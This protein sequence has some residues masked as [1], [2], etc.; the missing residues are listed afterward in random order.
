MSVT[1]EAKSAIE[2]AESAGKKAAAEA[3]TAWQEDFNE[4]SA[5]R[6]LISA[7]IMSV[8][9]RKTLQKNVEQDAFLVAYSSSIQDSISN[10]NTSLEDIVDTT[11]RSQWTTNDDALSILTYP[12]LADLVRNRIIKDAKIKP[13]NERAVLFACNTE[14]LK[15]DLLIQE[16]AKNPQGYLAENTAFQ[17]ALIKFIIDEKDKPITQSEADFLAA[18]E[19]FSDTASI[20][21]LKSNAVNLANN[22]IVKSKI[23]DGMV[24]AIGALSEDQKYWLVK[25][26]RHWF[27]EGFYEEAVAAAAANPNSALAFD[28][29]FHDLVIAQI[30]R[31]PRALTSPESKFLEN[32]S[33]LAAAAAK[34][35]LDKNEDPAK[36][37]SL[38]EHPA[39]QRELSAIKKESD[40]EIDVKNFSHRLGM[41]VHIPAR[42]SFYLIHSADME[43]TQKDSIY[44]SHNPPLTGYVLTSNQKNEHNIYIVEKNRIIAGP[45]SVSSDLKIPPIDDLMI[46]RAKLGQET[47]FKLIDLIRKSP[48]KITQKRVVEIEGNIRS[49]SALALAG[50]LEN[51]KQKKYGSI[52]KTNEKDFNVILESAHINADLQLSIENFASSVA[53]RIQAGKMTL[54]SSGWLSVPQGGHAI[55]ISFYKDKMIISN[56]GEGKEPGF[57]V[58]IYKIDPNDPRINADFIRKI[59]AGADTND[60]KTIK[61]LIKS[62]IVPPGSKPIQAFEQKAQNHGTCSY[63]NPKSTIIGMLY[64]LKIEELAKKRGLV[65][66]DETIKL[67]AKQYAETEYKKFTRFIRDEAIDDLILKINN[68]TLEF[69]EFRNVYINI[70]LR[71]LKN[72]S[73]NLEKNSS[74][75][76]TK[77]PRMFKLVQ[78]LMDL[79]QKEP[80]IIQHVALE[81]PEF[82]N[83]SF[84]EY[85]L[86]PAYR[87]AAYMG[88]H[89][90]MK[91]LLQ[92]RDD[93][94][95]ANPNAV[96]Y[97]GLNAHDYERYG[98]KHEK[99][100]SQGKFSADL[101]EH[102]AT[103]STPNEEAASQFY[104]MILDPKNTIEAAAVKR[105]HLLFPNETNQAILKT[106][107]AVEEQYF[108]DY[109]KGKTPDP[110]SNGV[111]HWIENDI[112]GEFATQYCDLM[113]Y[114]KTDPSYTQ[115]HEEA[116]QYSLKIFKAWKNEALTDTLICTDFEQNIQRKIKELDKLIFEFMENNSNKLDVFD[117]QDLNQ[118]EKLGEELGDSEKHLLELYHYGHGFTIQPSA[119]QWIEKEFFSNKASEI[120]EE[121]NL[122]NLPPK[123]YDHL[124]RLLITTLKSEFK[125]YFENPD[126]HLPKFKR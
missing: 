74:S 108:S 8:E 59:T 13:M 41:T 124:H 117:H 76:R 12:P 14:L 90:S 53:E 87:Y 45:F 97:Q 85:Y 4:Q 68:E 20:A 93:G 35:V 115:K 104:S 81:D 100:V 125:A 29:E 28:L 60:E 52:E 121:M 119:I 58:C 66:T 2:A 88:N 116:R 101:R 69:I 3:N 33:I 99:L 91:K 48:M 22:P 77:M 6:N 18:N 56:R 15:D 30:T 1:R 63:V 109:T 114:D 17:Q 89:E 72:T 27:Y 118:W 36:I 39:V 9:D 80:G 84:K 112:A 11:F 42:A 83:R 75:A 111:K 103:S 44:L 86:D 49:A 21:V 67:E 62:I 47:A 96:D 106:H 64:L 43:F 65:E 16:A 92:K 50:D 55:G 71:V 107:I 23:I 19:N 73:A 94:F 25:V 82:K 70:G 126:Q 38:K 31:K 40:V 32:N 113:H 26:R 10:G 61:E 98:F 46:G 123:I 110:D 51:Y 5:I 79:E 37:L 24:H 95:S 7:G 122:Y 105:V 54:I 120:L 57:G 102:H 34:V 78:A